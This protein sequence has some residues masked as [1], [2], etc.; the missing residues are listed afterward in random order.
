[1]SY[2]I[3]KGKS[4]KK[5]ISV[6]TQPKQ[7]LKQAL[8]WWKA[9]SKNGRGEQALATA[10]FI[11]DSQSYR[12]RQAA[13]FARLYSNH[14]LMG[15]FGGS[16]NK[17]TP[18]NQ[19]PM[20]RPTM[21]VVQSCV[22]TL[23]SRITQSR[24]RPVF[25]TDAGDYKQRN[26]AKQLNNFMNGEL[27][28]TKAYDLAK[29]VL[30]D[31]AVLGTGCIKVLEENNKVSLQRV[32]HTELLVD[33]AD[34]M[35][36]N[37]RQ[38][39]QVMLVDRD[40]L[41]EA[42]PSEKKVIAT[43]ED[44]QPDTSGGEKSAADQ[45]L[46]VEAW[47]LPSGPDAGD[48]RHT[49]VTSSGTILDEEYNKTKFPFVFI[50]YTPR[51]LGFFGQGLSE[52]L[53][54]TQMEINKLLVTITRSLN[55]VGVPKVLVENGSK[56]V[57]AHLNDQIGSI[58]TYSGTKP[59]WVTPQS[60][61]AEMYSQLQRLVDYAYQQS[62]I[63][64]LAAQSKKP[65]GLNSGVALR[66]FNDLQSDRFAALEKQYDNL[67]VDLAYLMIDLAKDIAE[68]EGKYQTVYPNKDGTK[69]IDL[70]KANLLDDTF[71]IQ[72]FNSSS[73]PRDPAGRQQKVV[74]LLQGGM[75]DAKEARRLLDFPD[76]QQN[77]KLENASEERIFQILDQIVDE[78]KFTP[79]DPFMD[80][81]L[82]KKLSNQYYNL[83]AT[84]KLEPERAQMLRDFNSQAI[85][86]VPPAPMPMGM[87]GAPGDAGA[88]QAVPEQAPSTSMLPMAG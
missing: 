32:L 21:N 57:K 79:P 75:I 88:V 38:M 6:R 77:E 1:M 59:E 78:G 44:V 65:E 42:F 15:A 22:D 37:P 48:G 16:L 43:A 33:A 35:Y 70:P 54:G 67:F 76:L 84:A 73:L 80:L 9:D 2:T 51:L 56:I 68:R 64:A 27:Y 47:H 3:S 34:A 28:Q 5:E 72:C 60:I 19:L 17:T 81:V 14:P 82:A 13:L 29:L 66:E 86:L 41:E 83:Y 4:G 20:D 71:V 40:M 7:V 50:Q 10:T 12:N 74:E 36:G 61:Q 18:S 24:P 53:M 63:S 69:E 87:P 85:A 55:T 39:Y 31:A 30:R 49:L 25:L 8:K 52:Q 46:V 26:L 58:V 45:V 23:V 62:G 11:K